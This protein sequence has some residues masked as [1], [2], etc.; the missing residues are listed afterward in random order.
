MDS[1]THRHSSRLALLS[2]FFLGFSLFTKP[3]IAL[4]SVV[5]FFSLLL[6]WG[7]GCPNRTETAAP[8][9]RSSLVTCLSSLVSRLS[10]LW[11]CAAIGIFAALVLVLAPLSIALRSVFHAIHFSLFRPFL[12]CLD[13]SLVGL[14]FFRRVSGMDRPLFHL[15]QMAA[16]VLL[17]AMPL[18]AAKLLASPRSTRHL[19]SSIRF[20]LLSLLCLAAVP[21]T[22]LAFWQLN[23]ALPLAPIVFAFTTFRSPNHDPLA[24]DHFRSPISVAFAVFAFVLSLKVIL[25]ASIS[26]YGFVLLLPSFLL[27]VVLAFALRATR[28]VAL[29]I[30]A[31]FAVHALLLQRTVLINGRF[32]PVAA[33]TA[34]AAYRTQSNVASYLNHVLHWLNKNLPPGATL[35]VLPEGA[36]LNVLSGHPNSTPYVSLPSTDYLRFDESGILRAYQTCPPDYLL[37]VKKEVLV[38]DE[39]RFGIDYAQPLMAFLDANY[40]PVL[41]LPVQTPTGLQPFFLLASRT[42][43]PT[44][45]LA[46]DLKP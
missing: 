27:A 3:E 5:S 20:A 37:L 38:S 31:A 41:T 36:V 29:A 1:A 16:G 28:P 19:P 9:S 10:P 25:N 7:R 34:P 46:V 13:S 24:T 26:F 22:H 42:L 43:N 6:F 33:P 40:S 11:L 15:A 12:D 17:V 23:A 39:P 8:S 32:V 35:A 2:G 18:A 4:A 30:L 21:L 45:P 14:D 44:P